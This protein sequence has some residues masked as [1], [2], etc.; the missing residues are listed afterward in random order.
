MLQYV[1]DNLIGVV[2]GLVAASAAVA[3]IVLW[4]G[5]TGTAPFLYSIW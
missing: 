3:V 2:A 4:A 5:S 1:R